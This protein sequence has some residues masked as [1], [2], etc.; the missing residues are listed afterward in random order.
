MPGNSENLGEITSTL[1][2]TESPFD[3]GPSRILEGILQDAAATK[4]YTR[5]R[6]EAFNL[7]K[8]HGLHRQREYI[9]RLVTESEYTFLAGRQPRRTPGLLI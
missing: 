2:S 9:F 1:L 6:K 5:A 8:E 3:Q 7:I 4:D